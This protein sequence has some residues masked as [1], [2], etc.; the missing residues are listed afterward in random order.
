MSVG[1]LTWRSNRYHRPPPESQLPQLRPIFG[2]PDSGS[3]LWVWASWLRDSVDTT[4]PHPPP[5][6]Q[7]P[8]QFQVHLP[9]T[10]TQWRYPVCLTFSLHASSLLSFS[11]SLPP[12]LPPLSPHPDHYFCNNP[13]SG[14]CSSPLRLYSS[15]DYHQAHSRCHTNPTAILSASTVSLL[16]SVHT[17]VPWSPFR[18]YR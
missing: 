2:I 5:E 16:L 14:N 6:S 13:D 17:R 8:L 9:D 4:D 12:S 1:F 15:S 11:P 10:L 18:T 7:L 3:Q